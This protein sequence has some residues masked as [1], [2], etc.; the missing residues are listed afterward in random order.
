MKKE[1]VVANIADVVVT[2]LRSIAN[3][4]TVKKIVESLCD[5]LIRSR[6]KGMLRASFEGMCYFIELV[7]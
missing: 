1:H 2:W 5:L 4:G 6:F 3:L 7:I